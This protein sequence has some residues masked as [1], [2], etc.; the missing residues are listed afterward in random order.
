MQ[1]IH[2]QMEME[3]AKATINNMNIQSA[4]IQSRIDQNRVETQLLPIEQETKRISALAKTMGTE[5]FEKLVK[6]A[7]LELKEM[8][9]DSKEE[10]SKMQLIMARENNHN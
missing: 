4:E 8:S 1:Q 6:F 10:I 7:E 2:H 5:D 9:I 3:Q